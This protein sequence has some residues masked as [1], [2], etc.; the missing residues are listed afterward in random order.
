MGF[1]LSLHETDL[2]EAVGK[3][4]IHGDSTSVY[5]NRKNDPTE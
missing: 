5:T 1:L 4:K 2:V 3:D